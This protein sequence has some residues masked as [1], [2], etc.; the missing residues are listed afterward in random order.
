MRREKFT[1]GVVGARGMVGRILLDL[2]DKRR[3]P[4][5][6]LNLYGSNRTVTGVR[7]RGRVHPVRP[8]EISDIAQNDVVF[9]CVDDPVSKALAPKLRDA[10]V[11]VI[12]ESSAFRYDKDVPLVIPE[13]NGDA[14]KKNKRL[15]AGPNCTLATLAMA[16]AP[17]HRKWGIKKIRLASYQAV[18]G[19]GRA[20]MLEL[21]AQAKA[22]ARRVPP[23]K[24]RAFK[25]RILPNL[26]PHIGSF[27]PA[28]ETS[29]EYK[30]RW[31]LHKILRAPGIKVSA[32]CVR[33]PVL[34]G[35]SIAAWIETRRR[36]T[37]AQ[38]YALLEKSPGVKV[39]RKV[40]DYPTP[41]QAEGTDPVY[42]G[43]VRTTDTASNELSMW[44]VGD[45]LLKGAALNVV[46]IAEALIERGFIEPRKGTRH[47]PRA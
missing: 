3:F 41:L 15:V 44:V 47:L 28:G 32:T 34:R 35:H 13:I 36:A 27:N 4:V 26:F 37:P 20:A 43:R 1:V 6:L 39:R 19:A 9:L 45:N 11:W 42:V 46:Q 31:E 8:S 17:I 29:E 18:S 5:G 24:P 21:D 30:V 23:P 10:G 40:E 2:L 14:L 33:V 22:F 7:W 25:H 12:D 16:A 38:V